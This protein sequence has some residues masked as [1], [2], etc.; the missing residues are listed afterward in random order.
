MSSLTSIFEKNENEIDEEL[1]KYK[2]DTD[3][4]LLMKKLTLCTL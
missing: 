2:P 4:I 3:I 1:K